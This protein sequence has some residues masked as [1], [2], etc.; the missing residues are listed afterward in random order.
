MDYIIHRINLELTDMSP[1]QVSISTKCGD[2]NKAV[3]ISL[4]EEQKSYTI[5]KG[6]VAVVRYK[7][8]NGVYNQVDCDIDYTKNRVV[9]KIPKGITISTGIVECELRLSS[10]DSLNES[11]TNVEVITS[12]SFVIAVHDSIL[13]GLDETVEEADLLPDLIEKANTLTKNLERNLI[14]AVNEKLALVDEKT[15]NAVGEIN[16]LVGTIKEKLENGDFDGT[17][18]THTFDGT[19]LTVTSASGSSSV[20]LKG[21]KGEDAVPT[22][23]PLTLSETSEGIKYING[24]D[25]TKRYRIVPNYS[26]GNQF[27]AR[28]ISTMS[29]TAESYPMDLSDDYRRYSILEV[30][31]YGYYSIPGS[32]VMYRNVWYSVNDTRR[33][34]LLGHNYYEI[35][36][37]RLSINLYDVKEVYIYNDDAVV[38]Y[39]TTKWYTCKGITPIVGLGNEGFVEGDMCLAFDDNTELNG[40]VFRFNGEEWVF[41]NGNIQGKKGDKGD[42]GDTGAKIVTTEYVGKDEN[43]GNVY[44]QVFDNGVESIFT[45]PKGEDG[46]GGSDSIDL[47]LKNGIGDGTVQQYYGEVEKDRF[48]KAYQIGSGAFGGRTQAGF[49]KEEFEAHYGETDRTGNPYETS[50]SFAFSTGSDT[51]A[52]G[53]ASITGGTSTEANEENA[54]AFGRHTVVNSTNAFGFGYELAVNYNNQFAVGQYNLNK[55]Y[56]IFEVGN[57]TETKRSNA[58]EV[59]KNGRIYCY[60]T[61]AGKNTNWYGDILTREEVEEYLQDK[62]STTNYATGD[63]AGI[64]RVRG[65]RGIRINTAS[66]VQGLIELEPASDAELTSRAWYKP[67]TSGILDKAIVVGISTNTITLTEGEKTS[68]LEWL[69]AVKKATQA[70]LIYGTTT[71]YAVSFNPVGYAIPRYS[72]KNNLK[73]STPV[74]DNDCTPKKYVDDKIAE[75][76]ARIEALESK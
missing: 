20:D 7:K 17:S 44:K 42:K 49:T 12:A 31:S 9:F 38:K 40:D 53:R 74:D 64:V 22:I 67:I 47:N 11:E 19:V 76:L 55:D 16:E 18:V 51:R 30:L 10:I 66:S 70:N 62:V 26:D 32:G 14:P 43:G 24:L 3:I 45:A 63:V 15:N 5:P 21:E 33:S 1:C 25:V 41:T 27:E 68:A 36:P 57:G 35:D 65:D 46:A 48:S 50:R 13:S 69:G 56:S 23:I 2:T 34:V 39:E 54:G 59:D 6:S 72:T 71:N 73:T 4:L 29:G 28:L 61:E 60:L 8:E 37:S 58:I 75:L 52:R